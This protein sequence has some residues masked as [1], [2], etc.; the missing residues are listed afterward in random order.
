[1][2][3]KQ[4]FDEQY[5][6][7]YEPFFNMVSNIG[8]SLNR[9]KDLLDKADLLEAGI[10]HASSGLL[11]WVD[12]KGYDNFDERRNLKFEVKSQKKALFSATG[13]NKKKTAIIKLTNTLQQAENKKINITADYLIIVDTQQNSMG[14]IQYSEVVEKYTIEKKDGFAC[15]I[16][17]EAITMLYDGRK[18]AATPYNQQ[19]YK[20]AKMKAQSD[21]VGSFF[22]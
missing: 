13:R 7:Q 14:I 11:K 8:D 19:T 5:Q 16:P 22:L 10:E 15:Q 1:M 2:L 17:I 21:Y 9:K 18:Y 12:Q 6:F 3:T 4:Q 20:E